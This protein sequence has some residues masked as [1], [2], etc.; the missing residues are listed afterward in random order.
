[1]KIYSNDE[2]QVDRAPEGFYITYNK[3]RTMSGDVAFLHEVGRSWRLTKKVTKFF[4]ESE[5]RQ[6]KA[7]VHA[8][9]HVKR[10]FA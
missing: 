8:L 5:V 10:R 1:M 7:E 4:S 2:Y 6:I 9:G 3:C